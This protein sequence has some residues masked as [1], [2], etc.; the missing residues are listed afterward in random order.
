MLDMILI[1]LLVLADGTEKREGFWI[2]F[3]LKV[4]V[5]SQSQQSVI[6]ALLLVRL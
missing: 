6:C 3:W 2:I 4:N 1:M 5:F